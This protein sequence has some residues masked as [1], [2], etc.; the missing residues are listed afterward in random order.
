M[1]AVPAED[2]GSYYVSWEW[3]SLSRVGW[4]EVISGDGQEYVWSE[5]IYINKSVSFDLRSKR[6][7]CAA[8]SWTHKAAI[9]NP[10]TVES[11]LLCVYPRVSGSV[12]F[13]NIRL[14]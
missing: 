7:K 6:F 3:L 4:L 1:D 13:D 9:Q 11:I 8:S 10:E 14:E 2:S 5:L 12:T